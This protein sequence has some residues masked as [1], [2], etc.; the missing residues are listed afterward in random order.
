M[1]GEKGRACAAVNAVAHNAKNDKVTPLRRQ[2]C[3]QVLKTI[4]RCSF[5][6]LTSRRVAFDTAFSNPSCTAPHPRSNPRTCSCLRIP[7]LPS[8]HFPRSAA[9]GGVQQGS[10]GGGDTSQVCNKCVKS[11]SVLVRTSQQPRHPHAGGSAP[12][13]TEFDC[14][15]TA[16]WPPLASIDGT[17]LQ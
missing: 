14:N 10:R 13:H 4:M 17:V 9:Q 16:I 7:G 5:C 6:K 1:C 2:D 15:L 12:F 3:E 11:R 8:L